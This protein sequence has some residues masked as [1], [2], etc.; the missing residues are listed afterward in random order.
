MIVVGAVCMVGARGAA[1]L[2]ARATVP[3]ASAP[4]VALLLLLGGGSG[5]GYLV[6]AGFLVRLR[7]GR[8][9]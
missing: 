7:R 1:P 6:L 8:P 3:E 2:L 5:F 4:M 9:W